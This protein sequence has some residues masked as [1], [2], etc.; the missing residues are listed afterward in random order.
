MMVEEQHGAM[1]SVYCPGHGSR[2]L[3]TSD[4]IEA[5]VNRPEGVELHWRCTCG[6]VGNQPFGRAQLSPRR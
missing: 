3:L 5:V 6:E 2:V 1:F 4:N